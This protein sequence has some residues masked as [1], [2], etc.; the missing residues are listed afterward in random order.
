MSD[1]D[2]REV[3]RGQRDRAID[4]LLKIAENSTEDHRLW[5]AKAVLKHTYEPWEEDGHD[6]PMPVKV[7]EDGDSD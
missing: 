2:R 4:V 1:A 7:V 5:A 3:I 6:D